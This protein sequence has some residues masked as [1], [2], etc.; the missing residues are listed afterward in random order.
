MTDDMQEFID[1]LMRASSALLEMSARWDE[2][3]RANNDIVQELSGWSE[4]F[5]LSLCEV[6]YTMWAMVDELEA[7]TEG[8]K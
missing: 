5:N 7:I 8:A 3:S 2:L 4:A 1:A 6:P